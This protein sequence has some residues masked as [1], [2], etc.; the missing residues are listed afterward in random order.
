MN[1]LLRQYPSV[2]CCSHWSKPRNKLH[3]FRV[4]FLD[5]KPHEKCSVMGRGGR[6]GE[7]GRA[8][9]KRTDGI[10]FVEMPCSQKFAAKQ[11]KV[12]SATPTDLGL[13][14]PEP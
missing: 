11:N 9:N 13:K 12:V 1:L 2:M 6:G 3:S 14:H 5:C 10:S 7:G 8:S 4:A